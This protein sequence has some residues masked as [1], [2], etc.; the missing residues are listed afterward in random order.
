MFLCG[1]TGWYFLSLCTNTSKRRAGWT[2]ISNIKSR[3]KEGKCKSEK[4]KRDQRSKSF[5]DK[6]NAMD[7]CKLTNQDVV[8]SRSPCPENSKNEQCLFQRGRIA[9]IVDETCS[10]YEN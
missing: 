8:V 4:E 7:L 10:A 5:Q 3:E 9:E 6:R 2:E 1:R